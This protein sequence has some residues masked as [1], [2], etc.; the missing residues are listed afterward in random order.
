VPW[1]PTPARAR[2]TNTGE[3]GSESGAGGGH[4]IQQENQERG[5]Q[6]KTSPVAG[7]RPGTRQQKKKDVALLE[8]PR[9]ERAG[10][11]KSCTKRKIGRLRTLGTAPEEP[12]RGKQKSPTGDSPQ[13]ENQSQTR[14]RTKSKT[15]TEIQKPTGTLTENIKPKQGTSA[16]RR[17]QK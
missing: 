7:P 14:T 3:L 13:Q 8:R 10:K 6:R 1:A 17:N 16:D 12:G 4:E 5:G 2:E 9:T 15:C 11:T